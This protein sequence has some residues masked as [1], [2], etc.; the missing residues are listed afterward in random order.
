MISQT[1]YKPEDDEDGRSPQLR[2]LAWL[3][4]GIIVCACVLAISFW[5]VILL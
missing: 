5:A 3:C 4:Y 2:V 1:E